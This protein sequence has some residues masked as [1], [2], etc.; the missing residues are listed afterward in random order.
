MRRKLQLTAGLLAVLLS[1]AACSQ[2]ASSESSSSAGPPQR[3]GQITVLKNGTYDGSWPA[4]LDPATNATGGANIAQM[5]A[6]YGGLFVLSA[7]A[8]GSGAKVVPNQAESYQVLDKGRTLK[9]KLRPGLT[10]TD[11]TPFDAD[12]VRAN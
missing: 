12:A 2:G 5:A 4:G 10:F 6:I 9:I 8:D 3:G 7:N 1:A 11:G